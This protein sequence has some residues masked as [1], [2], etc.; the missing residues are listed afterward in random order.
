VRA[1]D[2]GVRSEEQP[3]TLKLKLERLL[4]S[5]VPPTRERQL[6]TELEETAL[7]FT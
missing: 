4:I 1:V 2:T 6:V 3:E 5:S 7:S